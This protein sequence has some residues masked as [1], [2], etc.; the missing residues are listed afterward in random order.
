MNV[1]DIFKEKQGTFEVD[2]GVVH[3]FSGG[4]YSREM[5]IPKGFGAVSHSHTYDHF[6]ILG[7]GRVLLKT[8]DWEKEYSAPACIDI[9]AG[10]HH[11]ILA[12][13]DATWYCIHATNET[14]INKIEEV[15]IER[16]TS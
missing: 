3:H 10:I 5:L 4:L 9:K 8:D 6:S 16:K 12:L 13:E 1:S 2:L 7:K 14:E 15:L 11:M